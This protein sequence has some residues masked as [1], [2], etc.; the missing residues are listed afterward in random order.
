MKMSCNIMEAV[1]LRE[2]IIMRM[3]ES[4]ILARIY[5]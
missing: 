2:E 5:D 3:N 1:R 4:S